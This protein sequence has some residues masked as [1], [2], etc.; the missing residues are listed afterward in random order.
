VRRISYDWAGPQHADAFADSA[1]VP[2]P[3][4]PLIEPAVADLAASQIAQAFR[5]LSDRWMTVL[6]HTEI[7]QANQAEIGEILDLYPGEVATLR[8]RAWDG[9]RQAYAELQIED[10][11]RRE[12]QLILR[13]LAAFIGETASSHDRALVSE[14]LSCCDACDAVW[15][16]LADID[17]A[18][19]RT[20][21]APVFLGRMAAEYLSAQDAAAVQMATA[22]A[23]RGQSGLAEWE[24]RE[25]TP[26]RARHASRQSLASRPSLWI[27]AVTAAAAAVVFGL[28]I[29][30]PG[31]PPTSAHHQQPQAALAPVP[32]GTGTGTPTRPPQKGA[33]ATRPPGSPAGPAGGLPPAGPVSGTTATPTADPRP[34]A[35]A[36]SPAPTHTSSPA[37][38]PTPSPTPSPSPGPGPSPSP[39]PSSPPAAAL[40]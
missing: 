32:D 37:P 38:T 7:E 21:V 10:G 13:L 26:G 9:L 12:C 33:G 15:A 34:S 24:D 27:A 22:E 4:E 16:E 11:M 39:G 3:G 8:H 31:A 36:P 6:W 17:A 5:S 30:L 2:D 18:T 40:L 29:T 23:T 14:H 35:S 1:Q 20:T 19:L 28:I 25:P